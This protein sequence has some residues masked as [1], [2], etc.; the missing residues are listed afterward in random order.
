MHFRQGPGSSHFLETGG[1]RNSCGRDQPFDWRGFRRRQAHALV[2]A[3]FGRH[4]CGSA[5]LPAARSFQLSRG[6][7]RVGLRASREIS[8]RDYCD[9]RFRLTPVAAYLRRPGVPALC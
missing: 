6:D 9:F 8:L 1:G 3:N 2:S 4:G 5:D 7:E